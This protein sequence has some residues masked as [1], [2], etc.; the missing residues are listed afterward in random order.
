MPV[1]FGNFQ[2]STSYATTDFFVG[3]TPGT[4]NSERRI[5]LSN[6]ATSTDTENK[7]V[8]R[9]AS[10]GFSAGGV[11]LT[12]NAATLNLV[13]TDR[14]FIAWYPDGFTSGRQAYTGFSS[15]TTSHFSIV[16]QKTDGDLTLTPGTDARVNINGTCKIG[17]LNGVLQATAGVVSASTSIEIPTGAIM[18]FART[19]APTGW[20]SC[21]GGTI[22]NT[23][24][25]AEL[26][27]VLAAAE[28]PGGSVGRLPNL[29]GRFIRSYGTD[30]SVN[31]D[32]ASGPFGEKQADALQNITGKI[33]LNNNAGLN[34]TFSGAFYSEGN[35][36]DQVG[37]GAGKVSG[38]YLFDASRVVRTASETR[39]AN[40]ALLAC[41]KL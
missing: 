36:S 1:N 33:D 3:Y 10:G 32:V 4:P 27:A 13:G 11:T 21:D 39:P 37:F 12:S 14:T 19:T 15:A 38:G 35:N 8:L 17:T 41:I 30:T 20:E 23:G 28:W 29:R 2:E 40:I 16:N 31:P 22:P 6:L 25:Y 5:K 9:D 34:A 24:V 7:L 18:Y 26:Y